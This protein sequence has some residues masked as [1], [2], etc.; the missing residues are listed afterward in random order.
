MNIRADVVVVGSGAGGA[1]VAKELVKQGRD[2]ILLEKGKLVKRVG[3]QIEALKYYD[4]MAL[5]SSIEGFLVYSA[6]M[7]GG[8]TNVSCGNG[9][10]VLAE[11]LKSLGINLDKEFEET[12]REIG[13]HPISDKLIGKGSRIIMDAGNSLGFDMQPMPKYVDAEKCNSCGFCLFGC[14]RGAKWTTMSF[15]REM[16]KNGGRVFYDMDVKRVAIKGG[17]AVGVI[18]VRNGKVVRVHANTVILAAGGLASPVILQNSGIDNAGKS[19]FVDF[20]NVTFGMLDNKEVNLAKEITMSVVSTKYLND[21]GFLLSPFM[22]PPLVMMT[23]TQKRKFPKL[24]RYDRLLGIMTKTKDDNEG[25]VLKNGDFHKKPTVKDNERLD[26]GAGMARQI[27]I[28]AGVKN[29]NIFVVKPT[30]AHPGGSN[31][32]GKVVDKDLKT[33]IDNLYVC[34]A[35]VLPVSSGAPPIVTIVSL[36]KRLAKFLQN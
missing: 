18:A 21:K 36:G 10:P 28:K 2:V 14:K 17:K 8:T 31:P 15:V 7:G 26:E 13:V 4:R 32:I 33:G 25:E 30:G 9:M 5:R 29:R 35:S 1:S 3:T 23:I 16:H 22:F 24:L 19:L 34:D 12:E 6:I 27:L 20:L 11:E